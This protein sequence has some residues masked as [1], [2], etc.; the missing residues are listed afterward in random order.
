[1]KCFYLPLQ[2]PEIIQKQISCRTRGRIWSLLDILSIHSVVVLLIK[3][4]NINW[5]LYWAEIE[6]K[7]VNKPPINYS[8]VGQKKMCFGAINFV[9]SVGLEC[10]K[11]MGGKSKGNSNF[12]VAGSLP[13]VSN[14]WKSQH[15]FHGR[16]TSNMVCK[17]CEH[18][19]WKEI[20][21]YIIMNICA[22][23]E[24]ISNPQS[25]SWNHHPWFLIVDQAPELSAQ[26]CSFLSCLSW[27]WTRI[28]P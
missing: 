27:W 25:A 19:V 7:N 11:W 14:H 5:S 15:P 2:Q 28:Y 16:L 17:H 9:P 12:C 8:S 1:M 23:W 20:T 13:P 26:G 22:M 18:Q 6:I 21:F 24:G 4:D 3:G 10:W